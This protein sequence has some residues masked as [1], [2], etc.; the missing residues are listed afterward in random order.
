MRKILRPNLWNRCAKGG[1]ND[2]P[3]LGR[4]YYN[5]DVQEQSG[6]P[7]LEI[8]VPA[9]QQTPPVVCS[10]SLRLAFEELLTPAQRC[11]FLVHRKTPWIL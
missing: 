2:I 3:Q 9:S 8:P 4:P 1:G 11:D 5:E 6:R 10:Q 7:E